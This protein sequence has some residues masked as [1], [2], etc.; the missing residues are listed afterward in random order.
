MWREEQW[1]ING[2]RRVGRQSGG[3]EEAG[4]YRQCGL[5]NARNQAPELCVDV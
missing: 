4:G 5:L 1:G 3:G 2:G